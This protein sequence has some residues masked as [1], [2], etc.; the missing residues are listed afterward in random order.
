[1]TPS[2]C[3]AEYNG[4]DEIGQHFKQISKK[5][6]ELL[7]RTW[8]NSKAYLRVQDWLVGQKCGHLG[9][10]TLDAFLEEFYIKYLTE[11]QS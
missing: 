11:N 5:K 7:H 10:C 3:G 6:F 2:N 1:M 9:I 4:S 8:V